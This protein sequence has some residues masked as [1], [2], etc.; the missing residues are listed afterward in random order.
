MTTSCTVKGGFWEANGV[1]TLTFH[2]GP[3][4]SGQSVRQPGLWLRLE[5][6]LPQMLLVL[7][8]SA[9][10]GSISFSYPWVE[11]NVEMGGLRN[12]V[13][14]SLVNRNSSA[15]DVTWLNTYL[16]GFGGLKPAVNVP[17]LDGNPLGT[18]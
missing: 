1:S 3:D 15:A 9:P 18:R 10:G 8:G 16:L 12:I 5:Q 4:A 2:D 17:N 11:A 13:Q 6:Q 7:V 14:N